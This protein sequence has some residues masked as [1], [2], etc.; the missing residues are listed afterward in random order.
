MLVTGIVGLILSAL[1]SF[2]SIMQN[3]WTY[4][5]ILWLGM[6]FVASMQMSQIGMFR[7]HQ[8]KS[9]SKK[10]S[11]KEKE[12]RSSEPSP[13]PT[14][15]TLDTQSISKIPSIYQ[16]SDTKESAEIAMSES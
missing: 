3:P 4:I 14:P 1:I 7:I 16:T 13:S 11:D 10:E 6:V 5:V 9:K 8:K 2:P 12:K 15:D